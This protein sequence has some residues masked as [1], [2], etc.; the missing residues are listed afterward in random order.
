MLTCDLCS[1]PAIAGRLPDSGPLH[2]HHERPEEREVL[3][4]DPRRLHG[5]PACARRLPARQLG[6]RPRRLP[7]GLEAHA[8]RRRALH[9][10]RQLR[11]PAQRIRCD[12]ALALT[13]TS[14]LRSRF[15]HS[16]VIM[17]TS[18]SHSLRNLCILKHI[19][20]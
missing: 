13:R 12:C 6:E 17:S 9:V 10:P 20:I 3:H 1:E 19:A 7:P 18:I 11:P 16:L 4:E 14:T 2:V 15:K 8:S 5:A